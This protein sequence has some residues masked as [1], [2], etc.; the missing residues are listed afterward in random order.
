MNLFITQ[1]NLTLTKIS[2]IFLLLL[3]LKKL[4]YFSLVYLSLFSEISITFWPG[5]NDI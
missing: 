1:L 4:F 5:K 2:K 3:F